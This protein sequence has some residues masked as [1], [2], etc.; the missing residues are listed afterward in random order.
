MSNAI[1]SYADAV[2]GVASAEGQS[3]V[4]ESQ[5]GEF[6]RAVAGNDELSGALSDSS[7]PVARRQQI[8]EDLLGSAA[9]ATKAV[10]S[11]I[12]G[13]GRAKDL[14]A[15]AQA[16]SQRGASGR[17]RQLAEVRSAVPLSDDQVAR[18]TAALSQST[19]TEVEVQVIVDPS[20]VGGIVTQ[21]GDTVI[22][23]SVRTRLAQMRSSLSA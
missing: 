13:A 18:L 9:P 19:G 11:M 15:I 8:V 6:A 17:G 4:V 7:T 1:E 5:L 23:G 22:D 20:V 2:L 21:I 16:V 10:V 14:S 3:S 12:V